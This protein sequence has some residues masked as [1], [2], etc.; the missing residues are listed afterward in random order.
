MKRFFLILSAGTL[1]ASALA[2]CSPSKVPAE[3]PRPTADHEQVLDMFCKDLCEKESEV[4][5]LHSTWF[6][7][8]RP[9][10]GGIGSLSVVG[11]RRD[12]GYIFHLHPSFKKGVERQ[13]IEQASGLLATRAC[14][15]TSWTPKARAAIAQGEEMVDKVEIRVFKTEKTSLAKPFTSCTVAAMDDG[16][17]II[18]APRQ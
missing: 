4:K 6:L 12:G 16:D 17:K 11:G 13:K 10:N 5:E 9:M 18:V 14:G 2:S 7:I 3:P 1:L 8:K 15:S